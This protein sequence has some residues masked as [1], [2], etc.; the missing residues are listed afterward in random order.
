MLAGGGCRLG[1]KNSH[2]QLISY[3]TFPSMQ[4]MPCK[5]PGQLPWLPLVAYIALF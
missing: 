3:I 4:N 5:G 1:R 2:S